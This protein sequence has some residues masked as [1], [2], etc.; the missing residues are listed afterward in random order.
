[1]E[2][3][4]AARPRKQKRISTPGLQGMEYRQQTGL[5][6][7]LKNANRR[8][9]DYV[10]KPATDE[11]WNLIDGQRSIGDIVE[12]SLL[13]FDLRTDPALWLPV[14]AGW[15]KAGLITIAPG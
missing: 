3:S 12:Y 5:C 7:D 2:I 4:L 9:V 15:H 11:M 1:M 6:R 14:F 10:L 13:Q 8:F